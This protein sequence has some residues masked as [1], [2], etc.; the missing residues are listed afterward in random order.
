MPQRDWG[1]IVTENYF[2]L[3]GVEA[4]RGRTF[5]TE[6]AHGLNSDPY[7][8][9]SD[10]LWRRRF[11]ADPKVVGKIVE[12]NQHPFTV[13]GVAFRADSTARSS[14]SPPNISCR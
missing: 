11:G 6:D 5:H 2:D 4:A 8:V 12:I 7:I 14:A 10:G 1:L 9:L 3:L 13:I